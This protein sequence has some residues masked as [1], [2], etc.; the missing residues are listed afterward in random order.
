LKVSENWA[1]KGV[2]EAKRKEERKEG[3]KEGSKEQ[4]DGEHG[5]MKGFVIVMFTEYY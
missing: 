1:L 5:I 3:R 4:E 2:F